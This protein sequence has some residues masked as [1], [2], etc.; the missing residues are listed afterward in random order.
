M[1]R[2]T[3]FSL[4]VIVVSLVSIG[5]VSAPARAVES[6]SDNVQ[7]V[8]N[9]PMTGNEIEFQGNR[10]YVNEYG[11]GP[12]GIHVFRIV[13]GDQIRRIGVAPCSG[14]TDVAA[15]DD[16]FLAVSL[17]GWSKQCQDPGF[18][19]APT[20][21]GGQ[22]GGVQTVDLS[23]PRRA[24]FH[25][26]LPLAG[27][28]HTLTRYPGRPY[29]YASIGGNSRSGVP[30]GG[31][32]SI[33][34]VS[35]P[36]KPTL[37]AEY[38]SDSNPAGCH[39]ITFARID[40]RMIG[41]CP[42]TGGT[43]IWDAS[44]PLAPKPIGRALLPAIQLPHT[45]AVSSDG[46]LL[47]VS[48]EGYGHTCGAAESPA[49][50]IW[51]YDITNLEDPV[52]LSWVGPRRGSVFGAPIGALSGGTTSCT[53]HNMN[54]IPGEHTLVSAWVGGGTSVLDLSNPEQPQEVAHYQPEDGVAMSS[55]WYRG[56]VFVGDMF[57]G[58]D[59]LRI[60]L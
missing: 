5:V 20:T 45:A 40:G 32:T 28:T 26:M 53:A 13:P 17:Q 60:D 23:N 15:L 51:F 6:I 52:L 19:D 3:R 10:V 58:L 14:H 12:I 57:R 37:A 29:V 7:L 22:D 49:G 55:Y 1:N 34:D 2:A 48:D 35:D 42:G 39:D 30:N 56:R 43:E 25:E 31:L 4:A 33:I 36:Q 8:A 46:R 21:A 18:A 27:G 54:F 9:F 50:A 44:D 41:F 11:T 38:H 24:V 16:G 59:V 47:A